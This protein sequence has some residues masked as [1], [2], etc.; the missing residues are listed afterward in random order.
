MATAGNY[1]VREGLLF[2]LRL[3]L[4]GYQARWNHRSMVLSPEMEVL[5][6]WILHG[7]TGVQCAS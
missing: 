5:G 6:M 2:F 3:L 4:V 7:S 1:Y